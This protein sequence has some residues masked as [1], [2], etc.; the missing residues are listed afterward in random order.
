MW[1]RTGGQEGYPA[2]GDLS[3]PPEARGS[4]SANTLRWMFRPIPL[5]ERYRERYGP[6]FTMQLGPAKVVMV[7]DPTLAKEVLAGD[8]EVFRAGDTNGLFRPVVG[9]HSILLLDGGEHM[10]HRR[11]L[12]PAMG[13]GHG[14]QFADQVRE[15]AAGQISSWR[16]G[17][18]V[19]LQEEM[20]AIS[21]ASIMRIAF[22]DEAGPG[23]DQL[24]ELIPEMMDRCDSAF[25]MIPWFRRRVAGTTP[26]A[27]L[28]SVLD[29]VDAVLFEAIHD[30][31]ADPL[32]QMRDD[33]LSLL[34]RATHE[35][36][37]PLGD[38]EIRDEMLTLIMAGYETTTNGLAWAFERL[39]RA[40]DQLERLR[41][42]L[43]TGEEAYLDAVVKETL[44]CR[45]VVPVVARRLRESAYVGGRE[46]PEGTILMVSIYLVHHDPASY[47]E[48][49]SFKPERFLGGVPDGAAWIPFGGGV[50]RCLGAV[51]AQLEMKVVLREVLSSVRLEATDSKPE[52]TARKRF[53]FAPARGA[54]AV[55]AELIPQGEGLGRRRFQQP[56]PT[57]APQ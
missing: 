16:S 26:Y 32:T 8:P 28:M 13:G 50:R 44:R 21:F 1:E 42:E 33:A 10:H 36:G 3:P 15:I 25:T 27:R 55:V 53:T 30:R 24:R 11:I 47:P 34:V 38:R 29:D 31:R 56:L 19:R 7:A 12:L 14:Q 5:M 9:S 20:E 51:F 23:Q 2:E 37:S 18:R 40:P 46:I 52:E 41:A 54:E 39:L 57:A 35:D 4:G 6:I 17:Q 45:P 22:G 43:E 49:H 48:P